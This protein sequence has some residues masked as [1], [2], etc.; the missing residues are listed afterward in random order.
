MLVPVVLLV[1]RC[2]A[3]DTVHFTISRRNGAPAYQ[4]FIIG[5]GRKIRALA[6]FKRAQN[7]DMEFS[8]A[9]ALLG[10]WWIKVIICARAVKTTCQAVA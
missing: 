5:D 3:W 10:Y 4:I 8:S 6:G 1:P 9:E 7:S 2:A